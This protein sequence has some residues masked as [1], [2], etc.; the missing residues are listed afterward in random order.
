MSGQLNM[1]SNSCQTAIS[2]FHTAAQNHCPAREA[3]CHKCK[4]LVISRKRCCST[5]ASFAIPKS[6]SDN[7]YLFLATATGGST[8]EDGNNSPFLVQSY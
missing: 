4:G 5:P 3:Q 2:P 1:D 8:S 7:E 6:K